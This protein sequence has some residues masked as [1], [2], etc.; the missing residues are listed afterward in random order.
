MAYQPT[1]NPGPS[2][3][4]ALNP[5]NKPTAQ[6]DTVFPNLETGEQFQNI[7]LMQPKVQYPKWPQAISSFTYGQLDK[8]PQEEVDPAFAAQFEKPFISSAPDPS[9]MFPP[10]LAAAAP[11]HDKSQTPLK[12]PAPPVYAPK[13]LPFPA[14][15]NLP[16]KPLALAPTSAPAPAPDDQSCQFGSAGFSLQKIPSCMLTSMKTFFHYITHWQSLPGN[17]ATTK[18]KHLLL[19]NSRLFYLLAWF[20]ILLFVIA[21]T[22]KLLL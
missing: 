16:A 18:L 2:F 5:Q 14:K 3:N 20:V 9:L 15:P 6:M 11:F 19:D 22:R 13:Y 21:G 12:D 17:T 7:C 10:V 4:V 1:N 8:P